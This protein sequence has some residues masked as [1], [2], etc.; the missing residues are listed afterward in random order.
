MDNPYHPPEA[1]MQDEPLSEGPGKGT[2]L[3]LFDKSSSIFL[4]IA[5]I[6]VGASAAQ[7]VS[8]VSMLFA[9][10]P[11]VP[12][13]I[14]GVLWAWLGFT[15][16]A[17]CCGLHG[18]YQAF[19]RGSVRSLSL[20]AFL[21]FYCVTARVNNISFGWPFQLHMGMVFGHFGIGL[22]V[23]GVGMILWWI[24]IKGHLA[25]QADVAQL[26]PDRKATIDEL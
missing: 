25:A 15:G 13:N 2:T 10:R 19:R 7:V 6:L 26:R 4:T 8:L 17:V 16:F 22:N 23:V 12:A 5:I 20:L 1:T 3:P 11:A 18:G 24:W 21:V 14:S 9:S